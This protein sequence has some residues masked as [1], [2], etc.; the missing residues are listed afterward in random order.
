[1]NINQGGTTTFYIILT[2]YLIHVQLNDVLTLLIPHTAV[3]HTYY[4][5]V[6]MNY[7]MTLL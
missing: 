5:N 4:V 7:A 2:I 6:Q 3:V 1:M